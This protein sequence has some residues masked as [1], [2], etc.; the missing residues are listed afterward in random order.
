MALEIF[1]LVGSIFVDSDAA[2]KSLHKTDKKAE[3][4]GH[5]LANGIKQAGKWGAAIV[6]GATAA[7]GAVVNFANKTSEAADEIDKM[8]QRLGIG[9]ES[10]QELEYALSQSGVDISSF[11]SGTKTLLKNMDAVTEGNKTAIENFEK[12]GISVTD[13]S[14]KMR[15][16]EDV[17]WDAISAFQGMEDSAEK[18]RLA[19]E[20]FGKQGQ[21]ILPM[22]NAES[23]SIEEMR[24]QAHELGLVLDDEVIDSG[25]SLH[26]TMDKLT[27]SF[28]AIGAKL[29]GAVM[30]IVE[31][32]AN[33]LL[34]HMPEIESMVNEFAPILMD[35]LTQLGPPLMELAMALLP[36]IADLLKLIMPIIQMLV[37]ELLVPLIEHIA[38]LIS[39]LGPLGEI[40]GQVAGVI[41]DVFGGACE[42]IFGI[43]DSMKGAFD[44]IITFISG[45]FTGNWSKAWEG[46]KQ[47]FAGIWEG[48]KAAFK[49]P[50]NF[51]INGINKFI[52]GVNSIK[53]PDW[54]PLVGGRGFHINPIPTLAKGGI[55]ERGQTGLLEGDGAEAVVPLESNRRWIHAVAQDMDAEMGASGLV[56][57]V[58]T[59]ILDKLD[60]L[61]KMG[62]Y[63][64][65][66]KLAGYIA[67]DVDRALGRLQLQKARG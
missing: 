60:E 8:S 46:I 13:S 58:L 15:S 18:S 43:I 6:G 27:R 16:Q 31:K 61:S 12:L 20:L 4:V 66:R 1:K 41:T 59:D 57:S 49:A 54:V 28:S 67:P 65:G 37:A 21:E 52:S 2:D 9:R 55:L 25:V 47:I 38:G 42:W 53:V 32:L 24:K 64:D 50:I 56:V 35:M 39:Q 33:F 23:G 17:L 40:F 26:D 63:V 29:G 19:Q 7:V 22:L 51:I 30:P 11:S 36:P 44:G 10:Y 34:D 45:V 14:G 62:L 5:T 48:I 3:G